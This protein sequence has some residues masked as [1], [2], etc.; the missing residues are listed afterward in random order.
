MSSCCRRNP[1]GAVEYTPEQAQGLFDQGIISE[2][3]YRE[4]VGL[5]AKPTLTEQSWFWP[6]TVASAV[7]I[8]AGVTAKRRR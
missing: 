8:L 2:A 4:L 6:A 5:P 1:F 3:R 7:A